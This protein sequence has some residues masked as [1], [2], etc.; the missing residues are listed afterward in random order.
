MVLEPSV[1]RRVGGGESPE[2]VGF[3]SKA[4]AAPGRSQGTLRQEATPPQSCEDVQARFPM[5]ADAVVV[6][7]SGVG[8]GEGAADEG[9]RKPDY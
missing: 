5:F 6:V 7:K 1:V 9:N 2:H 3:V 4:A 8:G